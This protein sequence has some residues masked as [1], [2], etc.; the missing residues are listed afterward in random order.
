MGVGATQALVRVVVALG[1]IA[2][3]A[4][5]RQ[6]RRIDPGGMPRPAPRFSHGGAARLV[7][8]PGSGRTHLLGS[9]HPSQQNTQTGRLSRRML[10]SVIQRAVRLA[11]A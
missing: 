6:S 9:Y 7:L 10:D 3:D 5:L 8:R 2:W 4:C 11:Q 1:R